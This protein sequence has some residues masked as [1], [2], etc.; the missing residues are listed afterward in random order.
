MINDYLKT[1]LCTIK[2]VIESQQK[3]LEHVAEQMVR[4]ITNDGIIYAF[5]TGHSHMIPME[6][7]GRAGGLA[8]VCAMLDESVLNGGGARRSSK[9]ERLSGLADIIWENTPPS[10]NDMIFIISNSGRNATIVEMALKAKKE[11][12]LCVA[13]TSL[14]QTK[15]NVSLHSSGKKLFELADVVLDN[16]APDGDA[17]ITYGAYVTGPL[18]TL[19]GVIIVNS[20]VCE[21]V[22][23]CQERNI[24]VPLFQSQNREKE[25]GNDKLFERY[26]TRNPYF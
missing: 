11:G 20:L 1:S 15:S 19:T 8:N 6:L 14:E 13:I 24:P 22:R 21:A 26:S 25:T 18:S 3:N 4:T 7:F 5:G 2:T 17:Q 16:G 23:I 9:M 10:S 12:V